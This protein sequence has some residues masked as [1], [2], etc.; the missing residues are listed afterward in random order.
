MEKNKL[1]HKLKKLSFDAFL[2]LDRVGVHVLPKHYYTP[3][4]DYK[5]LR[6]NKEYWMRRAGLVGVAWNLDAQIT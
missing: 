1:R 4:P 5:W 6:E 3:V 2:A